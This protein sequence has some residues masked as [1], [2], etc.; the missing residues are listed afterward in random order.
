MPLIQQGSRLPPVRVCFYGVVQK[1]F[2]C[3]SINPRNSNY[4]SVANTGIARM[5]FKKVNFLPGSLPRV[6]FQIVAF[7][8]SKEAA[9]DFLCGRRGVGSIRASCGSAF[10]SHLLGLCPQ[11]LFWVARLKVNNFTYH[12]LY[13]LA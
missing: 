7:P 3:S 6:V 8:E 9:V 13:I 4:V 2:C 1:W 10:P 12:L 11:R 5:P